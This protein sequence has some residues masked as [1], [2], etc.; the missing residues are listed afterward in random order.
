MKQLGE[1]HFPLPWRQ[2]LGSFLLRLK[3]DETQVVVEAVLADVQVHRGVADHYSAA[4]CKS[5]VSTEGNPGPCYQI[6]LQTRNSK[7]K[8]GIVKQN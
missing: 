8:R 5:R 6:N 7:S 2:G 1:T 4:Y 3:L